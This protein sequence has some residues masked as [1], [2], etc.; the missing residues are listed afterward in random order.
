MD[1]KSK[2]S[3]PVDMRISAPVQSFRWE[4]LPAKPLVD[5]NAVTLTADA[6]GQTVVDYDRHCRLGSTL[7]SN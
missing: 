5:A 6:L 2:T 7:T 4:G 3:V 1:F